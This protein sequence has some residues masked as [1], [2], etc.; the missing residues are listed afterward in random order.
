MLNRVD[1]VCL[2]LEKHRNQTDPQILK[3]NCTQNTPNP[4]ICCHNI[5]NLIG[6]LIS[7]LPFLLGELQFSTEINSKFNKITNKK[8][9]VMRGVEKT[10]NNQ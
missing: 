7:W 10:L 1:T 9:R 4:Y 8:V 6:M 2:A 3:C 5:I